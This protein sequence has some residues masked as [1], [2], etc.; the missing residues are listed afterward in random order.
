[1]A[2]LTPSNEPMRLLCI[3]NNGSGKTG[4]LI[5]LAEAGYNIKIQDYDGKG[6]EII[7][8]MLADRPDIL[9][10]FDVE[11]YHDEYFMNPG[12]RMVPKP[13]AF[14]KAINDL[15][16]WPTDGLSPKEWGTDTILVVDSLTFQGKAAMNYVMGMKGKFTSADPKDF[17]PSQPDWGDAMGLQENLLAMLGSLKCHVIVMAHVTFV[18]ADGELSQKGF[19]SAL[20]NKLPPK[21]GSYFNSTLYYSS[22]GVGN[23]KTRRILTK[24]TTLVDTKTSAPGK[25]KDSYPIESGLR[26]YFE[27][28]QGPL[29]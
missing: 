23:N 1:M 28:L 29:K 26:E 8:N 22:E 15:V 2:A 13:S 19:P 3:G 17:H 20:G 27:A 16:K 18:T 14:A 6:T 11:Q 21:I 25:V 10:R 24:S 4:S 12:K 9:A 5:S 7:A